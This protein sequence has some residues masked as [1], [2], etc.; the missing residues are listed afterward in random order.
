MKGR[1]G[2]Q[3]SSP[4]C[5]Q[6]G[7]DIVLLI[8]DLRQSYPTTAPQEPHSPPNC[9]SLTVNRKNIQCRVRPGKLLLGDTSSCRNQLLIHASLLFYVTPSTHLR[10]HA[11]SSPALMPLVQRHLVDIYIPLVPLAS[12]HRYLVPCPIR[13]LYHLQTSSAASRP[14]P[15]PPSVVRPV[16]NSVQAHAHTTSSNC[17]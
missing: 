6:V 13:R 7:G 12:L 5:D 10:L 15:R 9:R 8:G 3:T 17:I 11:M 16:H 4:R 14:V 1:K 2:D